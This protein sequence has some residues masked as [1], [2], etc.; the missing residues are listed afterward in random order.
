MRINNGKMNFMKN[1]GLIILLLTLVAVVAAL[2]QLQKN[3]RNE[4]TN[5]VQ[6]NDQ[7]IIF[8]AQETAR[9]NETL[10]LQAHPGITTTNTTAAT[11]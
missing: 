10:H 4:I 7:M 2:L 6:S 8:I 5:L 1:V 9:N 11:N 3:E